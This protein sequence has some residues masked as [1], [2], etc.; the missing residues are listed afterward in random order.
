MTGLCGSIPGCFLTVIKVVMGIFTFGGKKCP[1][2]HI[3][4]CIFT[5]WWQIHPSNGS[6]LIYSPWL[7]FVDPFLGVFW[8]LLRIFWGFHI[9]GLFAARNG[10][11]KIKKTSGTPHHHN[12]WSYVVHIYHICNICTISGLFG[13]ILP[14]SC[15]FLSWLGHVRVSKLYSNYP[16]MCHQ[17]VL[18]TYPSPKY[19]QLSDRAPPYWYWRGLLCFFFKLGG[20]ERH[21]EAKCVC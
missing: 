11:P 19:H 5:F 8:Q 1:K 4:G 9:L 10:S 6:I 2:K 17:K 20:S 15:M 13:V 7:D 16:D 18:N 12:Y 3:S 21:S 14:I